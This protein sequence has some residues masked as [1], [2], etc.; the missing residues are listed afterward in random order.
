[1]TTPNCDVWIP[2]YSC[3][4]SAADPVLLAELV[5]AGTDLLWALS[6]RQY[7]ICTTVESYSVPCGNSKCALPYKGSDGYWRNG[8]IGT[9]DCC[10]IW[11]R[12]R[13][14]RSIVEVKIDGVV[15]DASAYILVGPKLTRLD[16]CFP[17]DDVCEAPRIEVKYTYGL[18]VTNLAKLALGEIVCEMLEAINGGT[19]RL[20]ARAVSVNRQGVQINMGDGAAL[21][22]GGL[23]GTPLADAFIRTVNPAG[24]TARSTVHSPDTPRAIG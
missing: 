13:P 4:V 12:R 8:Q 14:P 22:D 23:V 21:V 20:S 19:C 10:S 11:L 7:G 3:D 5:S 17:C 9:R 18:G 24:L 16:A 6:G 1:M 15:L 2:T